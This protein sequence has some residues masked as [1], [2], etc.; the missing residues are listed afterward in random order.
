MR[1]P[2]VLGMVFL[3]ACVMSRPGPA[4]AAG[5]VGDPAEDFALRT[6][7]GDTV[8][9][10]DFSGKVVVLTFFSVGCSYCREE[11]P[12]LEER[13]WQVHQSRGVQVLAVSHDEPALVLSLLESD[14]LTFPVLMDPDRQVFRA[15]RVVSVP[16]NLVIDRTGV[17]Q[18]RQVGFSEPELVAK[19][20]ELALA[21]VRRATW[22]AAKR[23]FPWGGQS[24]N[25]EGSP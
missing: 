23:I 24:D 12:K 21:P 11:L 3:I 5:Q 19:L 17:I 18:H 2:A 6:L 10:A 4:R 14:D 9:L 22:G 7:Q 13:I 15:Y 25:E 16:L 8:S 1:A 20:E